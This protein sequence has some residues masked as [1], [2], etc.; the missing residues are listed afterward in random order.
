[1]SMTLKNMRGNGAMSLKVWCSCGH[2]AVI[3][4]SGWRETI[5]VPTAL[6]LLRCSAGCVRQAAREG[7]AEIKLLVPRRIRAR[8]AGP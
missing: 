5:E 6:M 2:R 7:R 4:V 1:M 8:A 3:D